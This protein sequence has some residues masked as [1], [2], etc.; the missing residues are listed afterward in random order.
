MEQTIKATVRSGQD[1]F[2]D[3]QDTVLDEDQL[4]GYKLFASRFVVQ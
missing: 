1:H 4:P 3:W 2:A